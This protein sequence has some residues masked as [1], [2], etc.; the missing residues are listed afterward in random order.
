MQRGMSVVKA[1]TSSSKR[2]ERGLT[3]PELMVTLMVMGI[4]ASAALAVALRAFTDTGI[5]QNRRDI[6]GGGQIALQQMSKQIRQGTVVNAV[7]ITVPTTVTNIEI[8]TYVGGDPETVL[9]RTSGSGPYELQTSTDGGTTYRTVLGDLVSG[10]LFI[11]TPHDDS[12]GQPVV[13][14][15]TIDLQLGT[16]TSTIR[17]AS[18]VNL[19]NAQNL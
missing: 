13:D 18:D 3:I 2:G 7:P 15:I 10:D 19:R 4:I 6:Y 8:E 16:K 14:Q 12:F 1:T 17:I 9:W 5:V 11:L